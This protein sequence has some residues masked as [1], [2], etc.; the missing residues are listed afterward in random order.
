MEFSDDVSLKKLLEARTRERKRVN[1]VAGD[2]RQAAEMEM[3]RLCKIMGRLESI[4]QK[5][6][7][8]KNDRAKHS[9]KSH[10]SQRSVIYVPI[11]ELREKV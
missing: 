5:M 8:L 9:N 6:P 7:R 1:V 10:L 2:E 11:A 3:E 4:K